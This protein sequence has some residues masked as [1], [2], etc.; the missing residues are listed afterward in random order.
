MKVILIKDVKGTGKKDDVK[1]VKD[2]FAKYLITNGLAVMYTSKSSEVLNEQINKRNELE[3]ELVSSCFSLA[4]KLEALN[5]KFKVKIGNNG[6]VFGSISSKQIS[7]ELKKLGYD[8]DKKKIVINDELN[9]LG[10]TN[11]NV[12]LHKKVNATLRVTLESDK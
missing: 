9:V 5:L 1:D 8:I 2:G 7:E 12:I 3:N 11:V 4:K 10:T 6:K